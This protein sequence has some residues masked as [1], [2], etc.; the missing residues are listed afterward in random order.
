MP[1]AK[2]LGAASCTK[3]VSRRAGCPRLPATDGHPLGWLGS[4]AY[5]EI[6]ERAL[7]T[8]VVEPFAA[9]GIDVSAAAS[10]P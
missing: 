6:A 3:N 7:R 4:H 10:A 5:L 9:R 8:R 2:C 1:R